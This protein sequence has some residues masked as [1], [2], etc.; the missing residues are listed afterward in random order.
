M[1]DTQKDKGKVQD[2]VARQTELIAKEVEQHKD[3]DVD[4]EDVSGGWSISYTTDVQ[5]L[6]GGQ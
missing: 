4:L 3:E 2:A 5:V 6:D 1:E